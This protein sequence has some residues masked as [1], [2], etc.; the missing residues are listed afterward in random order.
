VDA[1]VEQAHTGVDV[2]DQ[3]WMAVQV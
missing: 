1:A 3:V 2:A